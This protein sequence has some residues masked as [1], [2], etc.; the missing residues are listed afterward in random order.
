[1]RVR[2]RVRERGEEAERRGRGEKE[3]EERGYIYIAI[4]I[5][6]HC[7]HYT[8][9]CP[10]STL[11]AVWLGYYYYYYWL[12]RLKRGPVRGD[13]KRRRQCPESM[14]SQRGRG[15]FP[16][17][18]N[19]QPIYIYIYIYIYIFYILLMFCIHIVWL[20][21][22][23]AYIPIYSFIILLSVLFIVPYILRERWEEWGGS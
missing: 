15:V 3:R 12:W 18:L 16:P 19:S 6:L 1:V 17:G 10:G 14:P 7:C 13:R 5:R 22:L 11:A 4:T 20:S 21:I 2:V 9:H 23:V 8:C